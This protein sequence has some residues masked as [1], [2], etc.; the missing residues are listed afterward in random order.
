M[1][2]VDVQYKRERPTFFE[3]NKAYMVS[4][5]WRTFYDVLKNNKK[6]GKNKW[7]EKPLEFFI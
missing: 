4:A 7:E 5:D 1:A 6:S 2:A 3:R